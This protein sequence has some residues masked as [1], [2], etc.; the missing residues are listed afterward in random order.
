VGLDRA[1]KTALL[2]CAL[3]VTAAIFVMYAGNVWIAVALISIAAAAHQG[4]SANL[5]RLASDLFPRQWIGSVVGLG[6]VGGA[7]GG[8][9]FAPAVGRYL[10]WSGELYGPVFVLCGSIYLVALLIIHLL[11]PSLEDAKVR[12]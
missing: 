11:V 12:G 5:F 2:V 8:M 1:R 4:W 7:I 6:G 10:K 9:L 3:A